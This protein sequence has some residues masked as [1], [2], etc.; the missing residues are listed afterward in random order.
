MAATETA[1]KWNNQW[2][3]E[4]VKKRKDTPEK[5]HNGNAVVRTYRKKKK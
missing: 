2:W 4:I 3:E 5:T 1:K